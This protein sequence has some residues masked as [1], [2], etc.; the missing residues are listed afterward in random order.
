MNLSDYYWWT[1]VT[2]TDGYVYRSEGRIREIRLRVSEPSFEMLV[3]WKEILD[4]M[5]IHSHSL[6]L[7][8]M[9]DPRYDRHFIQYLVREGSTKRIN[10]L[11]DYLSVFRINP[12]EY[13]VPAGAMGD[14]EY[15]WA[16][17]AGVIDGDGCIQIRRNLGNKR[18]ELLLKISS[19]TESPLA[20]I[21]DLLI[22]LNIPKGYLSRYDNHTDLWVYLNKDAHSRFKQ[23]IIKHM[24]FKKKLGRL[25]LFEA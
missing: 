5:T 19:A 6:L 22:S 24:S 20:S 2:H 1:G 4:E 8:K 17:L 7:E 10:F 15:G 18:N 21:Q 11:L 23:F 14:V 9:Y 3:K 13:T 12:L 16:Y 25:Q